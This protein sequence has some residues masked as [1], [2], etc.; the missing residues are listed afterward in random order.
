LG[1]GERRI[2]LKRIR[3]DGRGYWDQSIVK[4]ER[5]S[6]GKRKEE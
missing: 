6:I 2:E 4:E 3:R 1:R 5:K